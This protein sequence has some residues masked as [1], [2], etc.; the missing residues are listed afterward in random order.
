MTDKAWVIINLVTCAALFFYIGYTIGKVNGYRAGMK[1][2]SEMYD[3]WWRD[4]ESSARKVVEDLRRSE[5]D[6][7]A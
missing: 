1:K 5:N 2:A 7:A 6:D 4:W 3:D